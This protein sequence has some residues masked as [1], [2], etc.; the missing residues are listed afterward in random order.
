MTPEQK[1]LI[2]DMDHEALARF[3]R[4][5]PIGHPLII[6]EAGDYLAARFSKL[7]GMTTELSKRIGWD[8]R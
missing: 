6:G 8:P 3:W 7:G 1:A 4:F 2:D 5:A